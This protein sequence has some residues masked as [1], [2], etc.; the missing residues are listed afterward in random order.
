MATMYQKKMALRRGTSDIGRLAQQYQQ[1]IAAVTG[2]YESE[3]SKYSSDVAGKQ[4]TFEEQKKAYDER[5][6]AYLGGVE[7]YK[8]QATD[9]QK[10]M[11]G[12]LARQA[13]TQE[14][15]VQAIGERG[16]INYFN[17]TKIT[18]NNI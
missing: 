5:Y 10:S 11:E 6:G 4:K 1:E 15:L 8:K 17:I 12:Y 18:F 2:E 14:Q 7:Q 3:F 13:A 16:G 9:Y